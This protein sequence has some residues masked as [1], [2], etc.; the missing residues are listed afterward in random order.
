MPDV[1]TN[2]TSQV[3]YRPREVPIPIDLFADL[4]R[5]NENPIKKDVAFFLFFSF[6]FCDMV[7]NRLPILA[8]QFLSELQYISQ[9]SLKLRRSNRIVSFE[10]SMVGS[11]N[12]AIKL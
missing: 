1:G 11:T 9:V 5:R 7:T 12:V 2:L 10:A 4:L 3:V 6:P 8:L